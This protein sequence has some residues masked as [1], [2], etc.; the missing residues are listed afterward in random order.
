[1]YRYIQLHV[2]SA[3]RYILRINR[4]VVRGKAMQNLALQIGGGDLDEMQEPHC[5]RIRLD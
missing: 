4:K 5:R 2:V 1:M 3:I